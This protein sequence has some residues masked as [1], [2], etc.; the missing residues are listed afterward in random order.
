MNTFRLIDHVFELRLIFSL[1]LLVVSFITL[2]II[3]VVDAHL[4][5]RRAKKSQTLSADA[6]ATQESVLAAL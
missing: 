1:L 6:Y 3:A 2:R 5:Q 4:D